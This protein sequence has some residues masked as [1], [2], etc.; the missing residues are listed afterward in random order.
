MKKQSTTGIALLV[1][2]LFAAVFTS[3]KKGE[4]LST[5]AKLSQLN[6]KGKFPA[7]PL[8]GLIA[9]WPLDGSGADLSGNGNNGTLNNI[10]P[11]ADRFGNAGGACHFNGSS[12]YISVP[13]NAALRLS[14][15]DFTLNAW[16]KID[17]YNSSYGSI[18]LS[19]RTSGINNGYNWSIAGSLASTPRVVTYGPGGGSTNAIGVHQVDTTAWHMITSVYNSSTQELT[20]YIDGTLDHTSPSIADPNGAIT[21]ALDIGYDLSTG[22]YYFNGAMDDIR[23]YGQMLNSSAIQGLYDEPNPAKLIAYW[24][25]NGNANDYSG[26]SN[27]GT[28]NSVTS[29]ADRFGNANSAY[30]F[31]GSSSYISVADNAALR[32]SG[33]DFT[34][35]AWVKIDSYNSSYGSVILSKRIAGVNNGYNWSIAGSIAS[36]PGVVTYGPGGGS[37]NAIGT[38]P[39]D[40]TQWHMITSIYSSSSQQLSIYVDGTLDNISYSI[41]NPNGAITA[42][43]NIGYDATTGLYYYNGKLDDIKIYGQAISQNAITAIY[44]GYY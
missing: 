13:D 24:P 42:G 17:S 15:T 14:G 40:T 19:K 16:V 2:M 41:S 12:S 33:T 30:Y 4:N 25:F 28:L 39:V 32:L 22:L 10:T 35:N 38:N 44:N 36:V 5:D 18:I 37:T 43:L 11:V 27:N 20:T 8:V 7:S 3:C 31:D 23:I 1:V 29:V 9:Y 26:N 6:I 21:A 34:L